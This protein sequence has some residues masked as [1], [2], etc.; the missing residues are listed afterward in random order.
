MKS[1]LCKVFSLAALVLLAAGP[2]VADDAALFRLDHSVQAGGLALP[3]GV[4]EFR[5]SDRGVVSIYDDEKSAIVGVT[6][7]RREPLDLEERSASAT[8]THDAAVRSLS[9]G[10]FRYVFRAAPAPAPT[11]MAALPQP[12]TVVALAR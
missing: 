4:Y 3:A 10:D 12:T 5:V 1:S 8:L 9:I 6:L 11:T 2:A 7:A